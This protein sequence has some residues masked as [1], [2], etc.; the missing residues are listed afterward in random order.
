M[1]PFTENVEEKDLFGSLDHQ[2]RVV[3]NQLGNLEPF[4]IDLFIDLAIPIK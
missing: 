1:S 2:I 4:K 3:S